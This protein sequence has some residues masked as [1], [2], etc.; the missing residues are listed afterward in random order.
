MHVA[1][2]GGMGCG[3]STSLECFAALGWQTARSDDL[4]HVVY[5]EDDE[6]REALADRYGPEVLTPEGVDR[7]KLAALIFKDEEELRWLEDLVHPRVKVRW[8]RI[9]DSA[10]GV[11][12]MVEIPLLF[13]KGL[14]SQFDHTVSVVTSGRAQRGRLLSRGLSEQEV[15]RR[16]SRQLS[17]AEK[18]RLASLVLSNSGSLPFLQEQVAWADAR[19]HRKD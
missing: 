6:A 7:K 12:V 10:P 19:L 11:S 1:L 14:D 18:A 16:L 9:L 8:Q 2:T 13:E 3:K 4:V 5:R 15:D 17:L